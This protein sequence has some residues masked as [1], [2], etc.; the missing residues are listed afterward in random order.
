MAERRR[1]LGRGI[2]ALIPDS[3]RE[4]RL[5]NPCILWALNPPKHSPVY[6]KRVTLRRLVAK[7]NGSRTGTGR[8]ARTRRIEEE[9]T[10]H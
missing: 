4:S 6:W 7:N 8:D 9:E 10:S 1:G 5:A 3:Q 2:G